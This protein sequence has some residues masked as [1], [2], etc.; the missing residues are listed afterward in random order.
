ALANMHADLEKKV[1]ERTRELRKAKEDAEHANSA[2][3]EF[4]ANISHELRNPMHHILSYSKYGVE[5]IDTVAKEKSLHYFTQIRKSGERLMQLLNDLLDFSKMEA[6][7]M[8]YKMSDNN[9][10]QVVNDV[11]KEFEPTAREKELAIEIENMDTPVSMKF[12]EYRISQVIRNL[13]SNSLR[14]SPEGR[15]ITVSLNKKA[16][17]E[18]L[19][20]LP[21]MHVSVR[22]Q[23][24][25]I[26]EGE[27]SFI[28]DKFTQSSK[29]KTGAGG[30]GLGLAICEEIIKA[31]SGEIWAENNPEGGATFN[32]VLP[33]EKN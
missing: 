27:L 26:P 7:K 1:K 17:A 12:D 28:F 8:D 6:N 14:Y 29:T 9:L 11:V 16:F 3:S 24:V 10:L 33:L 25:G 22:D 30:T 21:A 5:K 32:F 18:E 4:L 23:G 31:H 2:K 15:N 19:E 20:M 13:L